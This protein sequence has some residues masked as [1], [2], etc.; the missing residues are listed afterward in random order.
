M[1]PYYR[2]VVRVQ[3][4]ILTLNQRI[5]SLNGEIEAKAAY[6]SSLKAAYANNTEHLKEGYET[7]IMKLRADISLASTRSD[8]TIAK[9]RHTIRAAR[10]WTNAAVEDYCRAISSEHV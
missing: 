2:F 8:M 10:Q 1:E 7:E 4:N 5:E 9:A 3:G 6:I